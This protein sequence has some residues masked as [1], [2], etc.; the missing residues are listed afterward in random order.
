MVRLYYLRTTVLTFFI[1]QCERLGLSPEL[2]VLQGVLLQSYLTLED[3]SASTLP[4]RFSLMHARFH[5]TTVFYPFEPRVFLRDPGKHSSFNRRS[6]YFSPPPPTLF[7]SISLLRSDL[8][9]HLFQ[10]L[11]IVHEP[12]VN[13]AS[14][15]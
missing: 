2:P 15:R 11:Y 8:F 3:R 7:P 4:R 1:R 12:L 13:Q 14:D 10:V 5:S 9:L 6:S